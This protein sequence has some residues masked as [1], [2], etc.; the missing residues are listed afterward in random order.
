MTKRRTELI[1]QKKSKSKYGAM[2][3]VCFVLLISDDS[4]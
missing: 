4:Y 1:T 2:V 3:G